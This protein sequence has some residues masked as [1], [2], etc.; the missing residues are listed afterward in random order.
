MTRSRIDASRRRFL[1]QV[2]AASAWGSAP[3]A[4]NLA[5]IGAAA[6]QSGED[7]R[8][9]VCVFLAGGND[10]AN[11]VVPYDAAG[12]AAY[13]AIRTNLAVPRDALA[14][15]VV[16]GT[17]L[18][19]RQFAL[20][21]ALAPLKPLYDQR[22]LAIVANVGNLVQPITRSQFEAK[23]VPV[24]PQLFSHSDQANF[25]ATS[26]P[27]RLSTTGWGGRLGDLVR[28]SNGNIMSGPVSIAGSNLFQSG[29]QTQPLTVIG[30]RIPG[31]NG[32]GWF[33]Q[34][35]VPGAEGIEVDRRGT[36]RQPARAAVA[37]DSTAEY[38]GGGHAQRGLGRGTATSYDVRGRFA[39]QSTGFGGATHLRATGARHA[40]A[41]LL[42]EPGHV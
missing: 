20:N 19:G 12:H 17:T 3:L 11:T 21:P 30:N 14:G 8:A 31:L 42:R 26:L 4:L 18:G 32:L 16:P 9:L 23:S 37:V 6:A 38:R 22:R 5:N 15:S 13:Q 10:Y 7:Y 1:H 29:A 33:G 35:G 2:A 25:F 24:P 27:D 40:P 28:A 34:A 36:P 39:R 41:D